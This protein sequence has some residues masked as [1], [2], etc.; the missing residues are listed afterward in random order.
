[1]NVRRGRARTLAETP[2]VPSPDREVER[3]AESYRLG[4]SETVHRGPAGERL[5]KGT[6]AS[7][8]FQDRRLYQAGDDVRHVDWRAFAR[9]DQ[10]MV[11]L[12]REEI[13]PRV[14]IVVDGSRS[15][16]VEEA[17]AQRTTDLVALMARVAGRSGFH[18]RVA[19]AG[20]RP[21]I[22][23]AG[24]L[25]SEGVSFDGSLPLQAALELTLPLLR[26]GT[27]RVLVSD[28]LSLGD[29]VTWVRSLAA[30]AGGLLLLQVLGEGDADPPRDQAL[31]LTDAES[32]ETLDVVLD[33]RT[34]A[35]YFD[36]LGRLGRD[37]EEESRR[38]GGIFVALD[39][40]ESLE[41]CCRGELSRSGVLSPA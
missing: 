39:T 16:A 31:R 17:K 14:E 36:R 26:P 15:M 32:G 35:A 5:G 18:A 38:V 34:V 12:Y 10:V 11:R 7:L 13:L 4:L 22:L 8:E 21:E 28:F 20:E 19:L 6:G 24:A 25:A 41:R 33:A 2:V 30:R 40:R 1:M 3:L 9:T 37:L 27:I 29:P 23:T